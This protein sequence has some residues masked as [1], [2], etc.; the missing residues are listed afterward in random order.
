MGHMISFLNASTCVFLCNAVFFLVNFVAMEDFFNCKKQQTRIKH[1][2]VR[3]HRE[4]LLLSMLTRLQSTH[5][6]EEAWTEE[7]ANV[8]V[9]DLIQ[10]LNGEVDYI[11]RVYITR[12][13]K[14]G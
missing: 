7:R 8:H 12:I 14:R 6:C 13:P 9:D 4:S 5:I 10:A 11:V 3:N 2:T 1:N